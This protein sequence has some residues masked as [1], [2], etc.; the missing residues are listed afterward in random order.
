MNYEIYRP[1]KTKLLVIEEFALIIKHHTPCF[2]LYIRY[3]IV[4]RRAW[5]L[6]RLH[7]ASKGILHTMVRGNTSNT[8]TRHFRTQI[9]PHDRILT[10]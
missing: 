7:L 6:G 4:A 2:A 10:M 1:A 3:P 5:P 8:A 9:F